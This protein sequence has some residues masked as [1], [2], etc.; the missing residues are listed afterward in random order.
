[1]NTL[2]QILAKYPPADV[3]AA[4]PVIAVLGLLAVPADQIPAPVLTKLLKAADTVGLQPGASLEQTAMAINDYCLKAE[5]NPALLQ[6]IA[7]TYRDRE[8][9]ATLSHAAERRTEALKA[10]G[11][12]ASATAPKAD[13]KKPEAKVKAAR[14]LKKK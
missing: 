6:E 13:K 4:A 2:D 5:V 11:R 10:V 12:K 1:M 3:K 9:Q 8:I 7:L 14:G